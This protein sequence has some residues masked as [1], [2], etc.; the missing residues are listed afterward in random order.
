MFVNIFEMPIWKNTREGGETVK[1]TGLMLFVLAVFAAG[2]LLAGCSGGGG[3]P[4]EGGKY[5]FAKYCDQLVEETKKAA[6]E[7]AIKDE[8]LDH[9]KKMCLSTQDEIKNQIDNEKKQVKAEAA[10]VKHMMESCK[11]KQGLDWLNCS[12]DNA[13]GAQDAA[14]KAIN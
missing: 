5:T 6:P 12:K 10:F 13:Q 3:D 4:T 8:D 11:D 14:N 7:G 1:K 9:A 2:S